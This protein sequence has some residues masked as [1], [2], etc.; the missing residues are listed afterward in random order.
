MVAEIGGPR[1]LT[2]RARTREPR[3]LLGRF[4]RALAL[5]VTLGIAPAGCTLLYGYDALPAEVCGNGHDDD[6]DGLIDCADPIDCDATCGERP[7]ALPGQSTCRDGR[8]NDHDGLIDGHDVGCWTSA[9]LSF[10]RCA[11]I[12]GSD[13]VLGTTLGVDWLS[14]PGGAGQPTVVAEP[15]AT[16]FGPGLSGPVPMP[17]AQAETTYLLSAS[18]STGALDGTTMNVDVGIVTCTTNCAGNL[19]VLFGP[20]LSSAGLVTGGHTLA[21]SWFCNAP[22]DCEVRLNLG[23]GTITTTMA[24]ANAW[25]QVRVSV[26]M[27]GG[28]V[29]V[30]ASMTATMTID[31]LVSEPMSAP[32][33]A[34]WGLAPALDVGFGIAQGAAV[35]GVETTRSA[36]ERCGARIPDPRMPAGVSSGTWTSDGVCVLG[37]RDGGRFALWHADVAPGHEALPVFTELGAEGPVDRLRAI[38]WDADHQ[39]LVGVLTSAEHVIERLVFDP[40]IAR[41]PSCAGP[42]RE[43]GPLFADAGV[44]IPVPSVVA[45]ATSSELLAFVLDGAPDAHPLLRSQGDF[46]RAGS[47]SM[48]ES[49]PPRLPTGTTLGGLAQ[50]GADWLVMV[51]A[52]SSGL[53]M[54]RLADGLCDRCALTTLAPSHEPGTFDEAAVGRPSTLVMAPDP[55]P[56]EPWDGLFFYASA[57]GRGLTWTHVTP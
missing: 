2:V 10:D 48:V 53:A 45:S 15:I 17:G 35:L 42:W 12:A 55:R 14:V 6:G 20:N 16:D 9:S 56:G 36:F 51:D 34:T 33:P 49:G 8:D 37:Q 4:S 32:L 39:E 29:G 25:R 27:T 28:T 7:S 43:I 13:L 1:V 41:A 46:T 22:T 52:D 23:S 50:L 11:T 54:H 47:F 24:P 5:V 18:P 40:S 26:T 19:A 44:V 31:D 38:A 3:I 21:L 30:P 57:T